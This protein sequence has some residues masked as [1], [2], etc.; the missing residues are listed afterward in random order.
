[1]NIQILLPL[2][3]LI[4][5]VRGYLESAAQIPTNSVFRTAPPLIPLPCGP[6]R[7]I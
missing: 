2:I 1:M 5:Y 6:Y 3:S 4:V 7:F